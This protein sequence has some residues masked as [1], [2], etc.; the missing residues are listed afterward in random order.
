MTGPRRTLLVV[1]AVAAFL[2]PVAGAQP[3][4]PV[5]VKDIARI[6][7]V[8]D[9]ELYGYGIVL[10]LNGTG[11]K[12]QSA[13]FAVQSLLNLL[14][15]Q[16][17]NVPP[18][19]RTGLEPKNL[20]AVMVTAKLPAFARAGT[21]LDITVSSIGDASSLPGGTLLMT[22]LYGADSQ[23]YAVAAGPVSLGGGFSVTAGST[24]ESAQKNHPTVGRIVGGATVERELPA[25]LNAQRLTIALIFPD[26]TTAARLAQT[27]NTAMARP[28]THAADAATVVVEMPGPEQAR[29]VEFVASVGQLT[30]PVNAPAKVV[31]NERTGTVIMGSQVRISTVAVSHGSLS[32]PI[33]EGGQG[34]PGAGPQWRLHRRCGHR[35]QGHRRDSARPDR[36]PAGHQARRYPE[37][38][39]G[40]DVI[41]VLPPH[42]AQQVTRD[43]GAL[44]LTQ[45]QKALRRTVPEVWSSEGTGQPQ[46]Y[47]DLLD[48]VLAANLAGRGGI[49]LGASIKRYLEPQAPPGARRQARDVRT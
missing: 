8:R 28:L 20:A 45:V 3:G 2:T 15:R 47:L 27:L 30:L 13:F 49:G 19:N 12:P 14:Q 7:G 24:G 42:G 23:V 29:F 40:G 4:T 17:I 10:G 41:L 9:N 48:E 35:P 38:R 31:I 43:F 46:V 26:F 18:L 37:R 36:H 5:R 16:G 33:K 44:F 25:T 22:P 21:T 34:E 32:I 11:D 1:L 39:V 6:A